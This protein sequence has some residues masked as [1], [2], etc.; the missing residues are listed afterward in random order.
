MSCLSSYIMDCI[1]N[2]ASNNV[3]NCVFTSVATETCLSRLYHAMA[4]SS[5]S[6]LLVF[7]LPCHIAPS[8]RLFVSSSPQAHCHFFFR[9]GGGRLLNSALSLVFRSLMED[10]TIRFMTPISRV[11]PRDSLEFSH[12]PDV[13][14]VLC[15]AL[16]FRCCTP[17]TYVSFLE[18][19][20]FRG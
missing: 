16:L 20:F 11:C 1:E 5:G 19:R 18:R 17:A 13:A 7:Q 6:T 8:L 9:S 3:L 10:P 14:A 4:V 15:L 2:T 12:F